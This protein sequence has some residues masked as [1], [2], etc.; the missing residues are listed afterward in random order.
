MASAYAERIARLHRELGI[1]DDYELVRSMPLQEEATHLV[2]ADHAPDT[3]EVLL[4][5]PAASA[6]NA[7]KAAAEREAV[8]FVAYSGFRSVERQATLVRHKLER[9][10][11][12]ADILLYLAAPGH[13]EHHTG[14]AIDV[15]AR[16]QS[17]LSEAF[18]TT[19]EFQWL[20]GNAIRFGFR[21]SYPKGNSH[22]IGYEPWHWF[23]YQ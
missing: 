12:M 18:E 9:G 20:S 14:R 11:A 5:Q 13:S 7:L 19:R 22:R 16:E 15:G 1:P 23:Y 10:H 17:P 3:Q 4:N 8:G 6:W 2:V 21:M